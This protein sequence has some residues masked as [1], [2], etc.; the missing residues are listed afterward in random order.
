MLTFYNTW[1]C[2][3]LILYYFGPLDWP[4]AA[5][6]TVAV[7]VAVCTLF[8]NLGARSV[9]AEAKVRYLSGVPRSFVQDRRIALVILLVF[10]FISILEV[11]LA[12]GKSLFDPRTWLVFDESVYNLYQQ[13]ILEG[14]NLSFPEQVQKIIRSLLFPIALTI[15]CAYFKKSR[16]IVFLFVFPMLG[17]SV[18]RGTSKE[19][20][21]LAIIF[22]IAITYNGAR[23]KTLVAAVTLAPIVMLVFVDRVIARYG[24]EIPTCIS[25]D[26]CFNFDS[27]LAQISMTLEVGYVLFASYV[28]QGYEGLSRALELPYQFTFGIG[29]LPPLQRILEQ[30]FNFDLS[31]FNERLSDSGWDTSWRWT[32]VYPVLANDFHWLFLPAYFFMVGRV[33]ALVEA[34]WRQ[35]REPTALA[36]LILI[37]IFIGYSSANMQLAV[38]LEWTFATLMLVYI[39]FLTA[40][41]TKPKVQIA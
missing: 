15:F 27:V 36:T 33:F 24:G 3:T 20:F 40:R 16:L 18:A 13:R 7:V 29:H 2:I 6:P 38:S 31:T 25:H 28:A 9:P 8:L 30:I 35:R 11:Q 10:F 34:V 26:I 17:M 4:G 14:N 39:P 21:D 5:D 37:T 19:V 12:T 22:L 32:S 23:V 1:I 41:V